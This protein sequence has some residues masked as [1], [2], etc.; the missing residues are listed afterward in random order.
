MFLGGSDPYRNSPLLAESLS[1]I[2]APFE[3]IFIAP[4]DSHAE[5]IA[6]LGANAK[7]VEL[8]VPT[9]N[10]ANF[11]GKVDAVVSAAGTSAWDVCSLGIPA[12][13]LSVVDNQDF[14]L[15]QIDSAGLALTNN[16]D[17]FGEEKADQIA[18]QITRIL[19]DK[20]LRSDLSKTSLEYFDGLGRDRVEEFLT[21][22]R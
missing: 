17:G 2:T 21:R 8:L 19:T 22:I 16:L 3:A 14:S 4:P 15:N 11:Y 13:L 5:V 1:K 9:P 6:K 10:L 18:G 7:S 20:R 12:L